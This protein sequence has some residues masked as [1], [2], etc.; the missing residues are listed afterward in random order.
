MAKI[1]IWT[2]YRTTWTFT[3]QLCGSVP[4]NPD[5]IEPW[6]RSRAPKNVPAA[7]AAGQAPTI[8]DLAD[9]VESTLPDQD[10]LDAEKVRL[11]TLGFQK[12]GQ[13]LFVRGGTVRAHIK[14]C[15]GQIATSIGFK[16]LRSHVANSCY[17]VEN[18]ILILRDGKPV[19]EH[20]GEFEQPVHVMTRQG[21]R[22]SLKRIRFLEGVGLVYTLKV[23]M[24]RLTDQH[25]R[26]GEDIIRAIH[27]YGETHGY[28]G[29]RGMG[30]GRYRWELELLKDYE[31][32]KTAA[33]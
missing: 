2:Y 31:E 6:L 27:D 11:I 1:R 18:Q 10:E 13:G 28:G 29:E 32:P 5:L 20:D 19:Q 22:N 16:N 21:P 17:I 15:A 23:M 30:S 33:S 8:D 12:N 4:Q 26:N 9:E 3:T 24:P 25:Y 7:V 14:D